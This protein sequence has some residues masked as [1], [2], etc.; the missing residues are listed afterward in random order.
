MEAVTSALS[1]I[2]IMVI[3]IAVTVTTKSRC[4]PPNTAAAKSAEFPYHSRRIRWKA[5]KEV[6]SLPL[7]LHIRPW[8]AEIRLPSLKEVQQPSRQA[9]VVPPLLFHHIILRRLQA[10]VSLTGLP[11]QQL[12]HLNR[13]DLV[14]R[15]LRPRPV[16]TIMTTTLT[17][18][19]ITTAPTTADTATKA[20]STR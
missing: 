14:R 11:L 5:T 15:R 4:T 16:I 3:T 7:R 6:S 12:A 18:I 19:I 1:L 8:K 13:K 9:P 20:V 10:I 2:I 17:T